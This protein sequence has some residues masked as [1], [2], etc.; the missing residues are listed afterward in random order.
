MSN[1]IFMTVE[2]VAEELDVSVS[3]AYKLMQGMNR[4]LKATGYYTIQGRIN[5]KFFHEKF[6][7]TSQQ[8]ERGCRDASV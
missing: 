4:E 6:Y 2:E 1:R 5:R 3:Y 7:G 8:G